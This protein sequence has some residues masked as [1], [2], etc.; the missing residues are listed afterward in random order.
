MIRNFLKHHPTLSLRKPQG[1][2]NN[3]IKVFTR[4]NVN[5]F[6][7]ILELA[8]EKI[9]FNPLRVS[10][11]SYVIALAKSNFISIVCLPPHTSHID[12]SFKN[13]L[14]KRNRKLVKKYPLQKCKPLPNMQTILYCLSE[15]CNSWWDIRF[16]QSRYFSIKSKHIMYRKATR[17]KELYRTF[18]VTLI[19]PTK[20]IV[21]IP[22]VIWKNS[23]ET[24]KRGT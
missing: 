23:P 11:C 14:F 2:L 15:M 16:L 6:F 4:E 17:E 1:I 5:V 7:D 19:Q 10:H 24:R 3:I 12:L 8:M 20:T 22:I 9:N 21:F 18:P 13:L